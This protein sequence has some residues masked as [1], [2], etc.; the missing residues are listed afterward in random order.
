M[1]GDRRHMGS[2][3]GKSD[4]GEPGAD[5]PP[6]PPV[7]LCDDQLRMA[8]TI[9][10]FHYKLQQRM[11][12]AGDRACTQET[13]EERWFRLIA[14]ESEQMKSYTAAMH[15]IATQYWDPQ[16][17]KL[18]DGG[19]TKSCVTCPPITTRVIPSNN[20][21]CVTKRVRD[22]ETVVVG[23]ACERQRAACLRHNDRIKYSLQCVTEYFLGICRVPPLIASKDTN[24]STCSEV[25]DVLSCSAVAGAVYYEKLPLLASSSVK[26]WRR[27]YYD[28]HGRQAYP[29]EI[30]AEAYRVLLASER[31]VGDGNTAA[32]VCPLSSSGLVTTGTAGGTAANYMTMSRTEACRRINLDCPHPRLLGQQRVPPLLVLDIGSC[33]GPFGGRSVTNGVLQVPLAVTALDLSPYEGSGVIK[34]DWLA[35]RFH[36]SDRATGR[37]SCDDEGCISGTTFDDHGHADCGVSLVRWCDEE[38][39]KYEGTGSAR[40]ILSLA[41]GAF[42]VVFFC[43]L[44]SFLPHPRLRYRACLHAYLAL[45]DGGLLVIVSTRTQGARR[46]LWVDEWIKCIEGIGFKRVHKNVMKQ[47]VGLSFS[48]Q[49]ASEVS[50]DDSVLCGA[51]VWVERMMNRADALGGL[52]T[53]GD[54]SPW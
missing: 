54:E 14:E 37:C 42:D 33:Y 53:I 9:K 41:R 25:A 11:T 49:P 45:K 23:S 18:R 43:L 46:S 38:S 44:L 47:I 22:T 26:R 5:L 8:S 34:A 24:R 13:E 27:T 52:R 20:A 51:E 39:G 10:S 40:R 12:T 4:V 50:G 29:Y 3:P 1:G 19:Q 32:P 30:D 6:A 36:D 7:D 35:I 21:I 15:G 31:T 16:E 17:D 28:T 2:I 48:K